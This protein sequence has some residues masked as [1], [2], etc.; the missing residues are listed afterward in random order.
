M[1]IKENLNA[2]FALA[3]MLCLNA[4]SAVAATGEKMELVPSVWVGWMR[5]NMNVQGQ[6]AKVVRASDDYFGD[7]DYGFSAELVLRNQQMVLLGLVDYIET[8]SS[9]VKVGNE[10]GTLDSSE[11]VGCIAL[12]YPLGSGKSTVDFL[13]GLQTLRLDNDLKLAGGDAYSDGPTVYDVMWMLRIKQELF[14][15]F[16]LNVPLAIGGTYLSDSEFVYDA[17]V[18][19]LYQVNGK[20][21]VRAGYRITGYDFSEDADSTDFYQQGYTLGVGIIF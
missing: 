19:L 2:K 21:D 7:L 11:I 18:Q 5:G 15:N 3:A 9:E 10:K 17:G 20:I 12:G 8:I 14:S 13:I 16:Y 6:E 4:F 1:G